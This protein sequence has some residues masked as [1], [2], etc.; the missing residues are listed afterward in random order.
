MLMH[1][2]VQNTQRLQK[3]IIQLNNHNASSQFA[4]LFGTALTA[5]PRARAAL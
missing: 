3:K 2:C 4:V 5:Y 1:V